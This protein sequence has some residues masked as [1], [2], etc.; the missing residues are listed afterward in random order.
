M[1]IL[2]VVHDFLPNHVA[3]VEVY[4]DQ[5]SRRLA[6]RHQ[7]AILHSEVIPEAENYS[8]RRG[9]VHGI[10]TFEVVNNH[11][12]GDFVQTYRNRAIEPVLFQVLDEFRP[13]VVHGQHLINLSIGLLDELRRRRIPVLFTLHDHWLTCANGG[14]RYHPQLGRCDELDAGRCGSCTAH[15]NGAPLAARGVLARSRQ[16]AALRGVI[17]L[18]ESKPRRIETPD[19]AFVYL[20][21]YAEG[22]VPKRTWVAHPPS[23]LEFRFELPRPGR[24]EAAVAMHPSTFERGGGAVCFRV[25]VDGIPAY[26]RTLDAKRRSADREPARLQLELAIGSH[27]LEL[28]TRAV[29]EDDSAFCT[30]GWI[31]PRVRMAAKEGGRIRAAIAPLK[32]L[33]RVTERVVGAPQAR[34]IR[35][36]WGE[37]RALSERVDLFI[38]PSRYL[39]HE[40]VRFGFS[41]DQILYSDY[42][43]STEFFSKRAKLPDRAKRF[44]FVGSV[45]PHK[46][47]HVLLEAFE[48]MPNDATLDVCGPLNYAP[49]YSRRLRDFVQH[50]GVRFVDRVAPEDV[51]KLLSRMD[52]LVVPSIWGENSPLTVHEAFLSGIPVVASSLGGNVELLRDGG[53][54]L[55]PADDPGALAS[56]LQ[57]LYD[58]PGLAQRL[59]SSAPA[60][61]PMTEHVL[62]L[63]ALYTELIEARARGGGVR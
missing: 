33:A 51:P 22:G 4:T 63:E 23:V 35:Q 31:D 28:E 54:L 6:E 32:A 10:S 42:G 55:Y 5:L 3:G 24:F 36:R 45:V 29:P 37:M 1:R 41:P 48:A 49:E 15:M 27:T 2:Q 13:E 21:S 58:E 17:A 50:P 38:A 59:A 25:R 18:A 7:V 60:V 20:D 19:S 26:E 46:G 43:F 8:L 30:A 11:H 61:K 47:V 39:K 34:R 14:Q 53:G 57:R 62:E 12:Y 56:Q 44:C 16:R 9:E 40:F 52:C